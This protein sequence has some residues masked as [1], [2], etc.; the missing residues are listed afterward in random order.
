MRAILSVDDE[1]NVPVL[2][3]SNQNNGKFAAHYYRNSAPYS[4]VI[5][6]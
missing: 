1:R 6:I 5:D 4:A 2:Y 3:D